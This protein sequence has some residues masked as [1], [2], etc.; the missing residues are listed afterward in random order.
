MSL[1]DN[2]LGGL[3]GALGGQAPQANPLMQA[4]M[5]LLAGQQGGGAGGL[6]DLVSAFTRGGMGDVVQSW[7]GTGQNLPIS[8][9]QLQQVLGGDTIAGLAKQLGMSQQDAGNGLAD[10]LPKL[11][12]SLTPQGQLPQGG[13]GDLGSIMAALGGRR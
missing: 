7:I 3:G 13:L 5:A 11:V 1:M 12:D 6:T 9:D 2:L 4:A 10:L 8:A